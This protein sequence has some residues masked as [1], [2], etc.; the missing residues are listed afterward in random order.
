[1]FL[2]TQAGRDDLPAHR[3]VKGSRKSLSLPLSPLILFHFFIYFFTFIINHFFLFFILLF[4][5]FDIESL[6]F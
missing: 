2:N 4:F 5:L 6:I 1:M 3:A